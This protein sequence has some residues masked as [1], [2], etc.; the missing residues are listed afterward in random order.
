M[1]ARVR[2]PDEHNGVLVSGNAS[3]PRPCRSVML[4]RNGEEGGR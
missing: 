1:Q 3:W 2:R 4:E